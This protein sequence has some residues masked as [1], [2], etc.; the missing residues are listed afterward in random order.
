MLEHERRGRG[1]EVGRRAGDECDGMKEIFERMGER[2]DR[3]NVCARVMPIY[4]LF[5]AASV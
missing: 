1:S 2:V 5:L 3:R 4:W